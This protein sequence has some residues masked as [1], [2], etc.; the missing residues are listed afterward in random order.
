MLGNLIAI[1]VGLGLGWFGAWLREE[2][3]K[4]Q[5]SERE[6]RRRVRELGVTLAGWLNAADDDERARRGVC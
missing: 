5:A 6:R 3:E 4:T 2:H 1:A